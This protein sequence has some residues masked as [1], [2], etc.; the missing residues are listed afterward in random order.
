M[1]EM[2]L[3]LP[4]N[5]C[6]GH[7]PRRPIVPG[8][9]Q[10]VLIEE[11]LAVAGCGEGLTVATLGRVRFRTQVAPRAA[12]VLRSEL[13][14]RRARF[15]L[16]ADG[17]TASDGTLTM[18]RLPEV[19]AGD[20]EVDLLPGLPPPAA[21]LPHA[22][23]MRLVE[24]VVA[25]LEGGGTCLGRVGGTCQLARG[26]RVPAVALVELA[27]QALAMVEAVS[28]RSV[29][30]PVAGYLVGVS[31][32]VLHASSV[33]VAAPLLATVRRTAWVPPLAQAEATIRCGAMV[34]FEG[35]LSAWLESGR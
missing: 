22:P 26:A 28:A 7:F 10:L 8:A 23:P 14:A 3:A 19:E 18:S 11:A 5:A 29:P 27:A 1:R 9:L 34:V 2:E 32:T 12:L 31:G 35:M 15:T 25:L 33:P 30:A 21:C 13:T 4:A 20:G 16:Q 17:G 24:G 6:S